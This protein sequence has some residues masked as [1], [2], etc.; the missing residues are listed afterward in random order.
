[1]SLTFFFLALL[2]SAMGALEELE[3]RHSEG[4]F[5]KESVKRLRTLRIR[6]STGPIAWLEQ[7]V[8]EAGGLEVLEEMMGG[9]VKPGIDRRYAR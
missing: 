4:R 2:L 7:F 8:A 6:L 9:L 1:M 3:L 5:S